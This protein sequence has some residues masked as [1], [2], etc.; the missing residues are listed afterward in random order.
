MLVL[1]MACCWQWCGVESVEVTYCRQHMY[2]VCAHQWHLYT[3]MQISKAFTTG[4]IL[5]VPSSWVIESA[6]HTTCVIEDNMIDC[7]VAMV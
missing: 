5:H 3:W 4:I 7:N 6:V 2:V 1:V